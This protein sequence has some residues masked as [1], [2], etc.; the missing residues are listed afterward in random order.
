MRIGQFLGSGDAIGAKRS[1]LTC[2]AI[3]VCGAAIMSVLLATLREYLPMIFTDDSAVISYAADLLPI[4]ATYMLFN[5][6]QGV[7]AG[8]LRGCGRQFIGAIFVFVAYFIIALPIGIPVMF[9]TGLEAQGFWWGSTIGLFV[10]SLSFLIL[11]F[12]SWYDL[13]PKSADT[14]AP[15]TPALDTHQVPDTQAQTIKQI[16]KKLICM[17]VDNDTLNL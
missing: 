8:I 10:E 12:R 3:G 11:F 4:L 1:G 6:I 15:D 17:T 2:I 7:C 14:Q 9:L 5:C 16:Q 13:I